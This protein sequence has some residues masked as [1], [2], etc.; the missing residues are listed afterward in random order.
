M[1][2]NVK[3]ANG[4]YESHL[5]RSGIHARGGIIEITTQNQELEQPLRG[6]EPVDRVTM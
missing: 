6:Y 5:Q 4:C 1:G 3:L 2:S